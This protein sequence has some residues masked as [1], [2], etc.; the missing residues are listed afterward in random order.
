M[1][2]EKTKNTAAMLFLPSSGMLNRRSGSKN[3]TDKLV[4][5]VAF[6]AALCLSPRIIL[7]YFLT[8]P[9]ISVSL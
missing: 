6:K 9:E 5:S 1:L 4:I 8:W 3:S 2:T 7:L